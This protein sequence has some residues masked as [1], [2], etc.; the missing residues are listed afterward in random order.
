MRFTDAVRKMHE[1][2]GISYRDASLRMGR[3]PQYVASL[4]RSLVEPKLD[5]CS[6]VADAFGYSLIVRGEG[7]GI[8]IKRDDSQ[9]KNEGDVAAGDV[10]R[11]V[12]EATP[13]AGSFTAW[14]IGRASAHLSSMISK[15]TVPTVY[16]AI[17]VAEECGFEVLLKCGGKEIYLSKKAD[18]PSV[19]PNEEGVTLVESGGSPMKERFH[20][21][22]EDV[23]RA[24]DEMKRVSGL[25]MTQASA[26]SG[27]SSSYIANYY[28]KRK[29]P[30]A[31]VYSFFAMGFG[32]DLCIRDS[33]Y[34]AIV[35]P[36]IEL[37]VSEKLV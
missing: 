7:I 9:V 10:L 25:S 28:Y 12:M 22:S 18:S 1:D 2:S 15:R 23:F 27:H 32:F 34:F 8:S 33:N 20:V 19:P 30:K 17:T 6:S 29:M 37:V 26:Q 13:F 35:K 21:T 24:I 4:L 11:R 16:T 14:K 31:D 3:N 36:K 5:V